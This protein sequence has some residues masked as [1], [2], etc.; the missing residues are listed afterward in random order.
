ML[1]HIKTIVGYQHRPKYRQRKNKRSQ[2]EVA[3]ERPVYDLMIFELH[4][5]RLTLKI[6]TKGE[7]VLRIEAVALDARE[8]RCGRPL[9]NFAR[10]VAAVKSILQRFI[11]ALSC[12]DQCF[13]ANDLLERLPA[14]A[15]VGKTKVGGIDLNK[16]RMPLVAE[17]V[18]ALSACPVASPSPNSRLGSAHW[19]NTANP[20]KV[21]AVPP[22]I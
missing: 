18:I 14:A 10:I 17:A 9:E 15:R 22:M 5:G 6:Y 16:P 19:V 3:V 12:I 1:L 13:I 20:S 2:W 7:R 11:D 21:L 4:C 8:L